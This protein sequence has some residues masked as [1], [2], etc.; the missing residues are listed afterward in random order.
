MNKNF[1][2]LIL[3]THGSFVAIRVSKKK[4]PRPKKEGKNYS[5]ATKNA[6]SVRSEV[7]VKVRGFSV[8][9]SLHS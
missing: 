8:L 1:H 4:N 5:E 3:I 6:L 2:K 7:A 9:P